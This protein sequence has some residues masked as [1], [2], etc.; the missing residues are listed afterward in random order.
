MG[1]ARVIVI[2]GASAGVGR[3]VAKAFARGGAG[4]EGAQRDVEANG[5][6]ALVLPLDVADAAALERGAGEVEERFG[7]I[8]VW[9]NNA[10]T[11]VFSPIKEMTPDEFKRVTEV[12]Y[13]GVIYG[14]LAALK[15]MLPRDRGVIIQVGSAL[16]YRGIPLQ[17]A[18]CGAK[19]AIQGFTESLRCELLHDDSRVHVTMIQLPAMNT[20]QFDW[21]KSRMPREP[22]P[23]PPIYAP[24]IAADAIVWAATHRRRELS[25][26]AP[27]AVAIWGNKIASGLF[28][29]YLAKTG[30][31]AQQTDQPADPARPHNL[32]TPV[33]GDHGA[34]GRFGARTTHSSP[35]AWANEHL[36]M[37]FG[38]VAGGV[39]MIWRTREWRLRP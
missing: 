20:P 27:T 34:H 26:G 31:D 5:G 30:Y 11:S 33:P 35:Q 19:H 7:P 28:D 39:A 18:Y 37:V 38:L 9:V 29:R 10:M 25:V 23:M 12:T 32:W 16:A 21:V 8:D 36:A 1:P 4:L 15:R 6:E 13:L 2:T 24:E 14:T 22:Q 3:A 17:A